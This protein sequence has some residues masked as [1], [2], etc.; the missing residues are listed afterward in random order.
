M[1]PPG[2]IVSVSFGARIVRGVVWNAPAKNPPFIRR[3]RYK[4]IRKILAETFLSKEQLALA[5]Y[6]AA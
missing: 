1:V 3:F 5:E 2:S 4:A 6:M